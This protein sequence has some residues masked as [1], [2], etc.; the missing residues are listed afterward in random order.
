M[1]DWHLFS[2]KTKRAEDKWNVRTMFGE[3]LP[4]SSTEAYK[5]LRTNLKFSFPD[6]G[7][8]KVIGITS[9][10]QSEGKSTTACNIAYAM[11][12]EGTKVLLLE[13]DLRRP[14]VAAKLGI[15]RKPGLTNMLVEREYAT[16]A[17]QQS[18]YAPKVDIITCGDIPPNPSELLG[19]E[20]MKELIDQLKGT[21]K[22]II[23]D[24]PPVMAVSDA[25][26]V[27]KCLDGVVMVVRENVTDQKP[28]KD[29][30]RQVKMADIR[31]LGFVFRNSEEGKRYS[32]RYGKY[33]YRNYSETAKK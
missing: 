17:I 9:A 6:D 13:A 5:V 18:P 11:A 20:R 25:V 29:A 7:L 26:A 21:Y 15:S 30:M 2:R 33:K 12:E 14:T 16:D 22:Y 4:F 23:M 1:R 8:G 10:E 31:V 28:L 19:S 32:Y 27:S 3:K 24:L